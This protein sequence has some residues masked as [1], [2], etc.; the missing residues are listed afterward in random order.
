MHIPHMIYFNLNLNPLI[1]KVLF[2]FAVLIFKLTDT[3]VSPGP[4]QLLIVK[5]SQCCGMVYTNLN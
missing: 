2:G 3:K 1:Y 5:V 4:N